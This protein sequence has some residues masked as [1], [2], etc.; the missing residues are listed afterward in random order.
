M[1][2]HGAFSL[3]VGERCCERIFLKTAPV[4]ND[5]A[6]LTVGGRFRALPKKKKHPIHEA[7][8]QASMPIRQDGRLAGKFSSWPRK[9]LDFRMIAPRLSRPVKWKNVLPISMPIT[10]IRDLQLADFVCAGMNVLLAV[11]AA[12]GGWRTAGPFH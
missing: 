3:T 7:P 9:S 8:A 10:A 11:S 2:D 4:A 6:A 12:Q 5:R 1:H